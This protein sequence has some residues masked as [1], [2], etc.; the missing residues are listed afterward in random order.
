MKPIAVLDS[1]ALVA[2]IGWNASDARR[3]LLLLAS[4]AFISVRT[5]WLTAEWTEVIERVSREL[6]WQNRNWPNWLDWIKN[7]SVLV[8]DP[9]MRKIVRRDLKDDPVVAAAVSRGAQYLVAYDRDLLSP[10][11]PY[12]VACVT[13]RAFLSAFLRQP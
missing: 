9:P 7:A 4:R 12:R 2:G 8:D 3:V 1:A 6:G 5:P 13:L 10:E 11:K